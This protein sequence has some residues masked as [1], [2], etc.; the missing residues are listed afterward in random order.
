[1]GEITAHFPGF[2]PLV[3]PFRRKGTKIT[4]NVHFVLLKFGFHKNN[5][6]SLA[7][8]GTILILV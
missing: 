7:Y 3:R 8:L 5:L 1:M 6:L 2:S 4:R